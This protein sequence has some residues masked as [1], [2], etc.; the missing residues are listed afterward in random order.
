M[1]LPFQT[2]STD[3]VTY[4]VFGVVTNMN[5]DGGAVIRFHDARCGKC[6]EAHKVLKDDFAGGKMPSSEF[7][8]NAAWWAIAILAM[9]L[10]SAMK[11]IVLGGQW[12]KRRMKAVRF[13]LINVPGRIV[14]KARQ[15]YLRLSGDHPA[16][17]LL[18]RMRER[19][20]ELALGPPVPA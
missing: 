10:A 12:A 18:V 16:L 9:N 11:R 15:L 6:E 7:G 19:I 2:I 4:K 5:W 13:L 17:E 8:A 20:R 14:L 3:G 1:S